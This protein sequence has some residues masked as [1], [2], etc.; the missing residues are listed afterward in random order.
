VGRKFKKENSKVLPPERSF[1]RC[2]NLET[3]NNKYL[4]SFEMVLGG[5]EEII[6]ILRVRTSVLQRIKRGRNAIST[7]KEGKLTYWSH[8]A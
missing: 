8:P 4:E 2:W 5:M 1:I 6:W 3:S 7:I